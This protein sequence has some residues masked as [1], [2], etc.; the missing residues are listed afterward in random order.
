MKYQPPYLSIQAFSGKVP[1]HDVSAPAVPAGIM[2]GKRPKRPDH[3]KLTDAL[4]GL[5][6]RCWAERAQDRPEM[7]EV[8]EALKEM[9]V[10]SWSM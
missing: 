3:P 8:V 5:T 7:K 2:D 9:S 1:F 6:E 4:W 10:C